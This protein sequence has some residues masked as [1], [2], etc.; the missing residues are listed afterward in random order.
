MFLQE[1]LASVSSMLHASTLSMGG[2]L[3]ALYS[4]AGAGGWADTKTMKVR[5]RLM[6]SQT[7]PFGFWKI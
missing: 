4:A 6:T 7:R 5:F 1:M 3:E 2:L